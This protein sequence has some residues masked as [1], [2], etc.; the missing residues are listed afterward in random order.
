LFGALLFSLLLVAVL[1]IRVWP[2]GL[3]MCFVPF[4]LIR[5][6]LTAD[7]AGITITN[8]FSLKEKVAWEYVEGFE[9]KETDRAPF[10]RTR[11]G[12]RLKIIALGRGGGGNF[13]WVPGRT[14]PEVQEIVREIELLKARWTGSRVP[15][16]HRHGS[17]DS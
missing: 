1:A 15:D 7:R 2:W 8:A 11:Y 16:K 5:R 10:V 17:D 4:V 3:V 13:L 12:D 6:K 14:Q 9:M